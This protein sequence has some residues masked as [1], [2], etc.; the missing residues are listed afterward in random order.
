[1]NSLII[2]QSGNADPAGNEPYQVTLQNGARATVRNRTVMELLNDMEA[3]VAAELQSGDARIVTT[4]H[5]WRLL[6]EAV[7]GNFDNPVH[8]HV[9][10]LDAEAGGPVVTNE[11][12]LAAQLAT[13]QAELAKLRKAT[14]K[15]I[16]GTVATAPATIDVSKLSPDQLNAVAAQLAAFHS[17]AD[18]VSGAVS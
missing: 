16:E 7:K 3:E 14:P 10:Q 9:E 6:I 15:Q 12:R 8:G 2:D 4:A 18:T 11:Q 13:A 1:M 5:R 17:G